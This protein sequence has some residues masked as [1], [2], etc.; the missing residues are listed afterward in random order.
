VSAAAGAIVL[1]GRVLYAW[2]F[3]LVAG[4]GHI[5]RSNTY[6]EMTRSRFPIP[7]ITGWPVGLWLVVG[8]GAG[9]MMF[10]TFVSLGPALRFTITPPLFNF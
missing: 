9:L 6:E 1:V 7:S 8:A 5:R 3:G 4:V 10:G 2:Y